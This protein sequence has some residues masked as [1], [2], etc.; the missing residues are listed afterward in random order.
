MLQEPHLHVGDDVQNIRSGLLYLIEVKQD[1]HLGREPVIDLNNPVQCIIM[2]DGVWLISPFHLIQA[3]NRPG[4]VVLVGEQN[5]AQDDHLEHG[6]QHAD[7]GAVRAVQ[8]FVESAQT[9]EVTEEFVSAVDEVN[10]PR[11]GF[12]S[13]GRLV[14]RR[15]IIIRALDRVKAF[16]H[17][18]G[19]EAREPF[20][21]L[22]A[23]NRLR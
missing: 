17:V 21:A 9:V 16:A 19:T 6:L 22:H 11:K 10:D 18:A 23:G 4:D 15:N 3:V 7:N 8:A 14:G 5:D 12:A 1:G 20:W 13:R 2:C